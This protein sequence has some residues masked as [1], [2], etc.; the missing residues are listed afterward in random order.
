MKRSHNLNQG[1]HFRDVEASGPKGLTKSD[2]L[3]FVEKEGLKPIDLTVPPPAEHKITEAPK[4]KVKRPNFN[5]PSTATRSEMGG[6]GSS[7]KPP[8]AMAPVPAS[9]SSTGTTYTDIPLTSMRSVI[10]SR[11]L[12]SKQASPHGYAT[13]EC[14]IDALG[15]IRDDFLAGGGIKISVNDLVIKAAGAALQYVPEVNLNVVG[16]DESAVMPNVDVSVAVATESGLITPIVKDVPSLALHQISANV[17]ELAGKARAG[18]LQLH[19]FQVLLKFPFQCRN[20]E[21]S[22]VIFQGG[23]FTISNLGMFGIKEFTAII[24]PPQCAILAVGKGVEEINPVTGAPSTYMRATL[25][26][27]RRFIDEHLAS[28]FMATFK[29]VL[30]HPEYMNIG[31]VPLVRQSTRSASLYN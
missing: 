1:C 20:E 29:K 3:E 18:R 27:D 6:P 22:N 2:V 4:Q 21:L 30:E 24:N 19:E 11:L 10:A 28:E 15:K 25:S 16:E 17:K 8:P 14:N 23:T 31:P 13:A 26:F 7:S 12:Q 5:R 9:T